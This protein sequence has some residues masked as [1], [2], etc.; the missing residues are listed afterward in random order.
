[1][2]YAL[3]LALYAQLKGQGVLVPVSQTDRPLA[4]I[5]C[6]DPRY[7][8]T[9]EEQFSR[10][11]KKGNYLGV[12]PWKG[13]AIRL[14]DEHEKSTLYLDSSAVWI[15]DLASLFGAGGMDVFLLTHGPDCKHAEHESLTQAQVFEAVVRGGLRLAVKQTE[16]RI[17]AD[18]RFRHGILIDYKDGRHE[19]LEIVD[20]RRAISELEAASRQAVG[21]H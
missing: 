10:V 15:S 3:M 11:A 4:A 21:A 5:A 12:L 13:G 16:G 6:V 2:D 20:W 9:L 1:M 14:S 17:A 19:L 18:V 7:R 8:R